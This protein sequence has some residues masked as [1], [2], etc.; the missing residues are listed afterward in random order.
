[1]NLARS[2]H[3]SVKMGESNT[4]TYT[5]TNLSEGQH[6]IGIKAIYLNGES[7]MAEYVIDVATGIATVRLDNAAQGEVYAIDGRR[8]TGHWNDLP[9]GI[10]L[11]KKNNEYIKV[12][13]Q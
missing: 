10:Y 13:K 8:M 6:T 4:P 5:F 3:I 1:M 2:I 7:D 9:R 11:V 12:Q